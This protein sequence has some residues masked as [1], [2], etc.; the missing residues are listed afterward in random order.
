MSENAL[1]ERVDLRYSILFDLVKCGNKYLIFTFFVCLLCSCN[2][3]HGHGRVMC[4]T[5]QGQGHL[6]MYIQLTVKWYVTS[7]LDLSLVQSNLEKFE[8][9]ILYLP[10]L[11]TFHTNRR[12]PPPK[13]VSRE[14]K[15]GNGRWDGRCGP[16]LFPGFSLFLQKRGSWELC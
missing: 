2:T 12:V 5:C 11:V 4:W 3:C 13:L 7:C 15:F 16:C 1:H 14:Q 10:F 6:K 9:T 8:N